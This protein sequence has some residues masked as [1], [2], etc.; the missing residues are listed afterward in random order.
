[1]AKRQTNRLSAPKVRA[2]ATP[3]RH[4][5]GAGLYLVVDPN[6][7]KRWAFLFRWDGKLKEMGL[8]GVLGVS[9]AKAREKAADARA[10]VADGVNPIEARKA[11]RA[12]PTFG[13]LADQT[14]TLVAKESRNPKHVAGWKLTLGTYCEPIRAKPV[15]KVT[16][17]DIV[18]ILRPLADRTPETASRLRGRI[19]RVMGAAIAKGY[20]KGPNPALWRDNLKHD[21]PARAKLTRGH[22]TALPFI[23][24]PAFM[25]RLRDREAMAALSVEFLILTAARSSEVMG[26]RWSEIDLDSKI[27][28]VPAARMKAGREHR[29][30]LSASALKVLEKAAEG[31]AK[32]R[33]GRP[34][35]YVFPTA[36]KDAP[37]S[38][39]A[40]RALLK[41]RMG[42]DVTAHGFRSSFRDWAGEASTFPREIAEAALAHVVG[43]A[44]ERAYRRGDALEKRRK[45]MEA[46]AG[47]LEPKRG[48]TVV[49]MQKGV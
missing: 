42:V 8:G 5:D 11:E 40:F 41:D 2:L 13:E 27:W 25:A 21:L 14:V 29:V 36:G 34:G 33:D 32:G 38:T 24:L 18:S 6:G 30:P 26:V 9:L 4:A 44:T 48:A 35:A 7:A 17:E 37:L 23:E 12:I 45:L 16:R 31:R 39:N 22:H 43:D 20:R 47:Y 3:G 10:L 19:E 46:W 49:P 15:D 28:T 1:M